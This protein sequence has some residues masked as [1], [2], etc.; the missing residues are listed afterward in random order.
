MRIHPFEIKPLG[1]DCEFVHRGRSFSCQE[2]HH[3]SLLLLVSR[4]SI[5][6]RRE[7]KQ[8][9]KN[10]IKIQETPITRNNTTV[11]TVKEREKMSQKEAFKAPPD[12]DMSHTRTDDFQ[13]VYEPAE[14]TY[15]MMDAFVKDKALL[16]NIV[17]TKKRAICLEVGCGSGVVTTYLAIVMGKRNGVYFATDINP[18]AAAMAQ[19]TFD[20][21]GVCME[22][23][24]YSFH[25]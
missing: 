20:K 22:F 6:Q 12:P 7:R 2:V 17:D 18:I 15:L 25:R 21:N 23:C 5:L 9:K 1:F 24:S 14:D 8:E 4:S 3:S 11:E 10:N 16:D 19:K 13:N